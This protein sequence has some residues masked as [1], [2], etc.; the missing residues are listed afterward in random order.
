MVEP[1]TTKEAFLNTFPTHLVTHLSFIQ[2]ILSITSDCI[3][4]TIIV[5]VFPFDL[6]SAIF[7]NVFDRLRSATLD[8]LL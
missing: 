8:S 2:F 3:R 4:F 1:S 7:R 5:N 6:S